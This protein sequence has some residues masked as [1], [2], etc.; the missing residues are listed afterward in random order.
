VLYGIFFSEKADQGSVFLQ[1]AGTRMKLDR[2]IALVATLMIAA[3][4][5]HC[6]NSPTAP[7]NDRTYSVATTAAVPAVPTAPVTLATNDSASHVQVTLS[8]AALQSLAQAA[9]GAATIKLTDMAPTDFGTL[10]ASEQ[11]NI[12]SQALVVL[13]F[14]VT[15]SSAASA[16]LAIA[17][18]V[19]SPISA[20]TTSG[21][22]SF[23]LVNNSGI[24]CKAGRVDMF[25]IFGSNLTTI[26]GATIDDSTPQIITASNVSV[27][28][29]ILHF[30]F[31]FECPRATGGT[32]ATN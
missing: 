23:T 22:T 18:A 32:G 17:P 15:K 11:A 29:N 4:L 30:I 12:G 7:F 16:G 9:G 28:L 14:D 31:S 2:R 20:Q 21:T 19:V 24:R 26:S 6:K 27:A 25:E 1:T 13:V 3:S 5:T 10:P 8:V